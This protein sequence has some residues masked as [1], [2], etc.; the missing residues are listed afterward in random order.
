MSM[1]IYKTD[2][3]EKGKKKSWENS[4]YFPLDGDS[5]IA[6]NKMDIGIVWNGNG[7]SFPTGNYIYIINLIYFIKYILFYF[8]F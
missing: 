6:L 4:E 7:L 1:V 5:T 8:Y 3:F 2:I